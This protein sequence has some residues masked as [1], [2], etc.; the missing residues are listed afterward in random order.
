MSV[1]A[2]LSKTPYNRINIP[3]NANQ[4]SAKHPQSG[5]DRYGNESEDKSI[6]YQTLPLFA[7]VNPPDLFCHEAL[8][9]LIQ[10]GHG[11]I[12]NPFRPDNPLRIK[13]HLRCL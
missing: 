2:S 1:D 8:R 6:L 3:V 9:Y 4:G 11:F 13:T 12:G 7:S 10:T 5:R